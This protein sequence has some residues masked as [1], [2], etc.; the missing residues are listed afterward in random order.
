[1]RCFISAILLVLIAVPAWAH[2]YQ[3]GDMFIFHPYAHSTPPGASYGEG[4][5]EFTNLGEADE[6]LLTIESDFGEATIRQQ[7]APGGAAVPV[8]GLV[9]PAGETVS[10]TPGSTH[11]RFEGTAGRPFTIGDKFNVTLVFEH[12]GA[13]TVEFWV[14]SRAAQDTLA[15][16]DTLITTA[17]MPPDATESAPI[18]EA[19]R[20][21]VS[22]A[23]NALIGSDVTISHVAIVENVALA[24]WYNADTGG[25]A[26]LRK[27]EDLWMVELFSGA[28]LVSS[29]GLRA[30]RLSPSAARQ[31]QANVMAAEADLSP[32]VR[33]R[34]D[35]FVGTV[36]VDEEMH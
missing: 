5:L 34:I 35:V 19:D 2:E 25:R 29:A 15:E 24:G 26:F 8:G 36:F 4:Y 28:S 9:L 11:V 6:R 18:A 10:L 16:Q 32:D 33:A 12:L 27:T 1:M 22:Q 7:A 14:E 30:Q 21:A 3:V 23:L 20:A 13:V 31:L 17:P